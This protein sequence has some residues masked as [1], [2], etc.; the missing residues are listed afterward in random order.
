ME[1]NKKLKSYQVT[2]PDNFGGNGVKLNSNTNVQIAPLNKKINKTNNT[3]G[4]KKNINATIQKNKE[5]VT[6][7]PLNTNYTKVNLNSNQNKTPSQQSSK[8]INEINELKVDQLKNEKNDLTNKDK[9]EKDDKLE[10]LTLMMKKIL[11]DN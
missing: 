9:Q 4:Q 8:S 5:D 3:V 7:P 1:E 2:N 11:E 10:E 6:L